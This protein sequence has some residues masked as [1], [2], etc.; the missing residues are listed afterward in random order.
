VKNKPHK[1]IFL[2]GGLSKLNMFPGRDELRKY[3][4]SPPSLFSE[5]NQCLKKDEEPLLVIQLQVL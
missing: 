4:K 5:Q 2:V 1:N 3:L